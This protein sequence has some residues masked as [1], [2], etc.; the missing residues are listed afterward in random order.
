MDI[1]EE[2]HKIIL[3]LDEIFDKERIDT[4]P[5]YAET[6]VD[7]SDTILYAICKPIADFNRTLRYI[8]KNS[9]I[10]SKP[11]KF[12]VDLFKGSNLEK[13]NVLIC[14]NNYR[15]S[16]NGNSIYYLQIK[17]RDYSFN[18]DEIIYLHDYESSSID[19]ST[20]KI[21]ECNSLENC[22]YTILYLMTDYFYVDDCGRL[23]PTNKVIKKHK[24]HKID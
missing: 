5:T 13:Y 1:K 18:P 2:L 7:I 12:P 16:E 9:V 24:K 23:F 17:H 20:R 11:F 4:S 6:H 21:R 10:L 15:R 14:R 3:T 22:Y 8:Q 19:M